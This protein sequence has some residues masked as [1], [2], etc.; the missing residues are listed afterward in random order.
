MMIIIQTFHLFI[1]IR[2]SYEIELMKLLTLKFRHNYENADSE[3]PNRLVVN[4]I[5]NGFCGL[6]VVFE[7]ILKYLRSFYKPL[8]LKSCQHF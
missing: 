3:V 5:M 2:K 4:V 1:E 7:T 8:H 6:T